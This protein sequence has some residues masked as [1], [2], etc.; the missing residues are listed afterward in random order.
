MVSSEQ[1]FGWNPTS[2]F[3]HKKKR[4]HP[5][6]QSIRLAYQIAEVKTTSQKE[7]PN[8]QH[9]TKNS[10]LPGSNNGTQ[11]DVSVSVSVCLNIPTVNQIHRWVQMVLYNLQFQKEKKTILLR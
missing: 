11:N 1:T 8:R 4:A 5:P 10:F 3:S 7:A 6:D 2:S 9:K